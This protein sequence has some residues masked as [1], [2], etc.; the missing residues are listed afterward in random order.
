MA[1]SSSRNAIHFWDDLWELF[2][3]N[4]QGTYVRPGKPWDLK[5]YRQKQCEPLWVYIQCVSQKCHE[6]PSVADTDIVSAFWD[7]TTCHSLDHEL[8]REQPKIAKALFGI[9]ARHAS[10]EEAVRVVF[11]LAEAGAATSGG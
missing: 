1:G 10:G 4:F 3:R 7:G 11:T 8:G 5:G 9:T 6:L 2:T